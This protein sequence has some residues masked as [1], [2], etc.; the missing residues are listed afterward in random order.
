MKEKEMSR[1]SGGGVMVRCKI[2][3]EKT[4]YS[5]QIRAHLLGK[6]TFLS[7]VLP[8]LPVLSLEQE[9]CV[10]DVKKNKKS[11]Y[12]QYLSILT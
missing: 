6:T 5:P 9:C 1:H 2:T 11:Q 12:D 8:V 10:N 4:R 3:S 7:P